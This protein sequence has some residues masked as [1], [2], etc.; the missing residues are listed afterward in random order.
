MDLAA[1]KEKVAPICKVTDMKMLAA[2]G[3]VARGED[4][5][6]SDIDLLVKFRK[7]I[8]F[9]ELF[10]IEQQLQAALGRRVDLGTEASLHPL[11]K[12]GVKRDLQIIYE[13]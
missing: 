12:A 2:F 9:I 10:D 4:S 8:G 13:G 6:A 3:S 1:I 7:P 5:A 11:I